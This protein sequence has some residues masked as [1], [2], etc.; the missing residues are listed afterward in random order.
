MPADLAPYALIGLELPSSVAP[1]RDGPAWDEGLGGAVRIRVDSSYVACSMA[2]AGL[3]I[4]VTDSMTVAA[5]A[6]KS[7]VRRPLRHPYWAEIGVYRPSYRPRSGMA[8][9]LLSRLLERAAVLKPLTPKRS[10]L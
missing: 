6:R 3:G 9:D 7:L 8:D 4:A 5:S 1:G 10:S 2:E